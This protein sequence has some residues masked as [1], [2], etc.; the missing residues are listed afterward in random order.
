MYVQ[1]LTDCMHVFSM[2]KHAGE[3]KNLVRVDV[4]KK[5]CPSEKVNLD[6][7]ETGVEKEII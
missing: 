7:R 3:D 2:I 6:E 5:L 4:F 1:L